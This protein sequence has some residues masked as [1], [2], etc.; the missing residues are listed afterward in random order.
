MVF[1]SRFKIALMP[2]ILAL[3]ISAIKCGLNRRH[4]DITTLDITAQIV[5]AEFLKP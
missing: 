2:R 3:L 1:Y 4:E 5:V